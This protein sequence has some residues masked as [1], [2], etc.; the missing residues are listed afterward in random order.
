[1]VT[2]QLHQQEQGE[3]S[4]RADQQHQD[5]KK[6]PLQHT[7]GQHRFVPFDVGGL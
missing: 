4:R 2:E 6:G 1:M 5:A 3:R 7:V